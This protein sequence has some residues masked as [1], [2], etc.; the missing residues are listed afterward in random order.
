MELKFE[1]YTINGTPEEMAAFLTLHEST[2]QR[3][4]IKSYD[5]GT[6]TKAMGYT[7]ASTMSIH[8]DPQTDFVAICHDS[9]NR[10]PRRLE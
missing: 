9:E 8:P 2:A 6:S 3:Q 1:Q 4:T 7:S 10:T 5:E